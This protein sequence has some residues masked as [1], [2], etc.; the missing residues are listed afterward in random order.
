MNTKKKRKK[1][2]MNISRLDRIGEVEKVID[3]NA[4]FGILF[5]FLH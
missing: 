2:S 4:Y 3:P 5:N 1:A